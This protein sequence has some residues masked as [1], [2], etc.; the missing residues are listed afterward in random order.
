MCL[1]QVHWWAGNA[2]RETLAAYVDPTIA[3]LVLSLLHPNP[4]SR[5][6]AADA[7]QL[8]CLHHV[9][10]APVGSLAS[11]AEPASMSSAETA[12][13]SPAE[14]AP[15][16]PAGTALAEDS[17]AALEVDPAEAAAAVTPTEE[18]ASAGASSAGAPA[19]DFGP[20][21]AADVAATAEA[22]LETCCR[23]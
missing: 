1:Q 9:Q 4:N 17:T 15:A 10:H 23:L 12:L 14:T 20:A 18:S 2:V 3:A 19:A 5:P 21:P 16:S 8:P 22:A 13:A 6:T 11:S 7:L